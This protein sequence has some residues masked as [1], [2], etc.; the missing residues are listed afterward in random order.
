MAEESA[1]DNEH[2]VEPCVG[3][4]F[5]MPSGQPLVHRIALEASWPIRQKRSAKRQRK[6][7]TQAHF[8][9]SAS[10]FQRENHIR[11]RGFVADR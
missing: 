3:A 10:R 4:G 11:T 2:R 7:A 1:L 6:L 9:L 8:H 5:V